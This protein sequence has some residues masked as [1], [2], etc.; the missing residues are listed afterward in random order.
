MPQSI[1]AV[2]TPKTDPARA[3]STEASSTVGARVVSRAKWFCSSKKPTTQ[4]GGEHCW[5]CKKLR[6]ISL[7]QMPLPTCWKSD[8]PFIH[9][10]V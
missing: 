7:K 1:R 6:I 10:K 9:V 8:D 2:A 4:Y 3:V 5:Y